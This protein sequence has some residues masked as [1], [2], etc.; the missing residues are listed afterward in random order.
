M[1][2]S[3]KNKI[4]IVFPTKKHSVNG[5]LAEDE[6]FIGQGGYGAVFKVCK[7]KNCNFAMY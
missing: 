7:E 5:W 6:M 2:K 1:V 3:R 4:V